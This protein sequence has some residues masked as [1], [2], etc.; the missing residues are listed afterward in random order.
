MQVR[1]CQHRDKLRLK[2]N[3]YSDLRVQIKWVVWSHT[4]GY[5]FMKS[6]LFEARSVLMQIH[7]EESKKWQVIL[8]MKQ[9]F[10]LDSSLGLFSSIHI[11]L[12]KPG[13]SG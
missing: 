4:C 7:A 11:M 8:S 12:G 13:S 10:P 5:W 9:L 2:G 6:K 3:G 1:V